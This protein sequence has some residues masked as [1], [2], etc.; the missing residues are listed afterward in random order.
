MILDL[1]LVDYEE[2][3]R[4]QRELVA[5]RKLGEIDDSLILAEHEPVFTIG[6]TGSKDNLLVDEATLTARGIKVLH[7]DRGGDI[8]FH[9][10]G[11]LIAYPVIDLKHRCGDLHRYLR[12]LEEATIGFLK[13]YGLAAGR[14]RGKTGVWIAGRKIASIGV[15][16]SNWITYH[17][18]SVNVNV[19]LAF[20][21][22]IHL[23]GLKGISADSL[24][25]VLGR[26]VDMEEAKRHLL[27]SFNKVFRFEETVSREV[28]YE[29]YHVADAGRGRQ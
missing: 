7:V 9:G 25:R 13:R 24:Q 28:P 26:K 16:A 29:R 14:I 18:L 12:Y 19:D 6:R 21:S 5:C 23:C 3:Y 11:Q 17:G 22:M 15:G 8:T 20:F 4:T 27:A 1:G 10:P 2:A